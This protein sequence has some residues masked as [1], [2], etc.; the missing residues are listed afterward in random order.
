[1]GHGIH[2][3]IDVD[4]APFLYECVIGIHAEEIQT[5]QTEDDGQPDGECLQGLFDL[6]LFCLPERLATRAP[7]DE[8]NSLT[9]DMKSLQY[10]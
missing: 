4:R 1:M 6:L 8:L 10:R 3:G 7:P 5:F 9:C 2:G